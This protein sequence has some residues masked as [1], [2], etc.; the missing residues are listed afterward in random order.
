MSYEHLQALYESDDDY[1]TDGSANK[2]E[3]SLGTTDVF[4][5]FSELDFESTSALS[6]LK[7]LEEVQNDLNFTNLTPEFG[8][9]EFLKF[10]EKKDILTSM[11]EELD[12]DDMNETKR[13]QFVGLKDIV[14]VEPLV[15]EIYNN[16]Q[17]PVLETAE[18]KKRKF[19][20]WS[21]VDKNHL[22]VAFVNCAVLGF[23]TYAF[24][25]GVLLYIIN[26]I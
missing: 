16:D 18:P 5:Q 24:G 22:Q 10:Q 13:I 15:D 6:F 20:P 25:Y 2:L 21:V 11:F 9:Q 17:V 7:E 19:L 1:S 26:N 14:G 4:D 3:D 8:E 23:I 12:E